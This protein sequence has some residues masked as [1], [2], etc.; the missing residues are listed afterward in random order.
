MLG[1]MQAEVISAVDNLGG[2]LVMPQERHHRTSYYDYNRNRSHNTYGNLNLT[3]SGGKDATSIKSLKAKV[4]IVLL[5][6]TSPEITIDDPLKMKSKTYVGRSVEVNFGG[7]IED[8]NNKGTYMLEVTAKKIGDNDAGRIDYNWSNQIW[9]KF[10]LIDAEGKE[11][12][13]YGPNNFNNNGNTVTMTIQY[14]NR[15]RRNGNQIK[16]GP[17]VRFVVNEWHTV[18]HEVTFEFKD[19]PLP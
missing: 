18:T 9:N 16:L 8:K 4:G 15:D 10:E 13:T 17:P 12:Q 6:G 1:V 2:S 7:L 3:S 14:N 5:S 11:Y 19:I